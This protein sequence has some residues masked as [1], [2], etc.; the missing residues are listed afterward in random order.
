LKFIKS[1]YELSYEYSSDKYNIEKLIEGYNDLPFQNQMKKF[2]QDRNSTNIRTPKLKEINLLNNNP[3]EDFNN[4]KQP[5]TTES[6]D[7]KF[8]DI[9]NIKTP[10]VITN[11]FN[12]T[13]LEEVKTLSKW[14]EKKQKVSELIQHIT[15]VVNVDAHDLFELCAF[16]KLLII[17]AMSML[18]SLGIS[19]VGALCKACRKGFKQYI[20]SEFSQ[21]VLTKL[22]DK[23]SVA[24]ATAT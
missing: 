3:L 8:E 24:D 15:N 23:K 11:K 4:N 14:Q 2:F 19:L 16:A 10:T 21:L 7:E 1:I 17:D 18:S 13:W 22:R 5:L 6:E 20:K 12:H 9:W